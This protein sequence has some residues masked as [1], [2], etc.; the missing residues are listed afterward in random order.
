MT[1][2]ELH[3]NIKK[4]CMPLFI[5][6]NFLGCGHSEDTPNGTVT[7][8]KFRETVF[9]CTCKH[10]I[11][12]ATNDLNALKYPQLFLKHSIFNFK[13]LLINKTNPSDYIFYPN[14]KC[15]NNFDIALYPVSLHYFND[16][17]AVQGKSYID[18][19]KYGVINYQNV[20]MVHAFGWLSEHKEQ[21]DK[22]VITRLA[23]SYAELQTKDMTTHTEKFTIFSE[24]DK[25][26]GYFFS[27]MSGGPVVICEDNDS[28][29]TPF[30]IVYEGQPGSKEAQQEGESLFAG[31]HIL[32]E[33]LQLNPELFAEWVINAKW[34]WEFD[35]RLK[36]YSPKIS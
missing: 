32:Y 35:E 8:I 33:C 11:K 10:V 19:D 9:L 22:E 26:H 25:N 27:G 16:M 30:G 13:I 15:S 20:N 28:F 2:E 3:Q 18:L 34:S 29:Y 31:N 4:I 17:L 12:F 24:L 21:N 5:E 1:I 7:F 23:G 6:D 14:F 36:N